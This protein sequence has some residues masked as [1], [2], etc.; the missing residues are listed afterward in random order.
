MDALVAQDEVMATKKLRRESKRRRTGRSYHA[1]HD[2]PIRSYLAIIYTDHSA[3]RL[4]TAPEPS[5]R[6][7]RTTLDLLVDFAADQTLDQ[8]R[9]QVDSDHMDQKP[10][11]ESLHSY[12][13]GGGAS[14]GAVR[15]GE[16]PSYAFDWAP[17]LPGTWMY[18]TPHMNVSSFPSG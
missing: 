2:F 6:P 4:E 8:P 12:T 10:D 13:T 3:I 11:T 7:Q 5:S 9:D 18:G 15:K 14:K 17:G 1:L 16:V